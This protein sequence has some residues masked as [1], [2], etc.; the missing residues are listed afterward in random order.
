MLNTGCAGQ[1][2]EQ[3]PDDP[4][5]RTL[6]IYDSGESSLLSQFLYN[7][8]NARFRRLVR[9]VGRLA[10]ADTFDTRRNGAPPDAK[11]YDTFLVG[12]RGAGGGEDELI[13]NFL[14]GFDFWDA[15]V[16][17]FFMDKAGNEAGPETL[18][19]G[20]RPLMSGRDFRY[21]KGVKEREAASLAAGWM[22]E[23]RAELSARKAVG[24]GAEEVVKAFAAA[25]PERI[26]WPEF[27]FSPDGGRGDWYF[28]LDGVP[29][30]YAEGRFLTLEEAGKSGDFRPLPVYRYRR[31]ADDWEVEDDWNKLASRVRSRR[32]GG[33]LSGWRRASVSPEAARSTF[34][35]TLYACRTREE[36]YR[37]QEWISFLGSAVH[38]HKAIRAPLAGVEARILES[39]KTD[40]EI[41]GW[42]ERLYSITSWNW[43]N[44]AGSGSRSYHSY[45]I[46]IDLLEIQQPGKETYWQ[47]TR[48]KGVNWRTV[49][50]EQRL[51][52]PGAVIRAF[53]EHGFIWGGTW[54]WYDT[55]HFEYR[56]ELLILGSRTT[57]G[58]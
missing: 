13:K 14:A 22:E 32:S 6:L 27:R 37:Q 26:T 46:A 44:V 12:V 35:E 10:Y 5:G 24:E 18:I 30:A 29:Y 11:K 21:R 33:A 25:F 34:Y 45:G 36:A 58:G 55:M 47:W 49:T 7:S 52:P 3:P 54:P 15:A 31:Q 53:E 2:A 19:R 28:E 57:V 9:I 8:G 51:D 42:R 4:L 38:V 23:L 39:E 50:A 43:R 56:P 40:K 1:K 20:A 41:T 17:P 16:V 48:S